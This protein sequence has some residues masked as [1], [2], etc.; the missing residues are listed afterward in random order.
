ATVMA[1]A[2]ACQSRLLLQDLKRE[3]TLHIRK[4]GV[5]ANQH[6]GAFITIDEDGL[7]TRMNQS[8]ASI[9]G[10][11]IENSIGRPL[12]AWFET[13]HVE[14]A[15]SNRKREVFNAKMKKN[16]TLWTLETMKDN[17]RRTF[18]S[19]LALP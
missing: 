7:I 18:R 8:A 16:T 6:D 13:E 15:L 10:E 3:L 2:E 9:L 17:R 1:V 4:S 19:A 12:T 5:M 11:S 14:A